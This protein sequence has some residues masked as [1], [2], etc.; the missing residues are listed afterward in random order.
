MVPLIPGEDDYP[1]DSSFI[2]AD[3]FEDDDSEVLFGEQKL[4]QSYVDVTPVKKKE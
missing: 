4:P 2:A 1:V 3:G